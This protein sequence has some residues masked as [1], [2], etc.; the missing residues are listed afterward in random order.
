MGKIIGHFIAHV[1]LQFPH[2]A[3]ELWK[4]ARKTGGIAGL[5]LKML[6][7]V[8]CGMP[9][10][11]IAGLVILSTLGLSLIAGIAAMAIASFCGLAFLLVLLL[12]LPAPKREERIATQ[13]KTKTGH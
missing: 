9:A 2:L 6:L 7:A 12:A 8:T 1:F 5:I 3:L 13:G 10:G 11:A 4:G